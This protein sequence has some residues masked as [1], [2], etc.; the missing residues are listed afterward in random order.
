MSVGLNTKKYT[1]EELENWIEAGKLRAKIIPTKYVYVGDNDFYI[2]AARVPKTIQGKACLG[3]YWTITIK[4]HFPDGAPMLRK[5]YMF[6]GQLSWDEARQYDPFYTCIYLGDEI[7]SMDDVNAQKDYLRRVLTTS[8]Y[9]KL[10]STLKDPFAVLKAGDIETLCKVPGIQQKTAEK[11]IFRYQEKLEQASLLAFVERCGINLNSFQEIINYFGSAEAAI[12]KIRE[13]P[14]SLTEVP[15]YGFKKTDMFALK[16]GV[17]PTSVYRYKALITHLIDTA[18]GGVTYVK[19]SWLKEQ[20]AEY[21]GEYYILETFKNAAMQ[22][23]AENKL[24]FTPDNT[25]FA[26]MENMFLESRILKEMIRLRDAE[27]ILKPIPNEEM[28]T[29]IR[30]IEVAQGFT[31]TDEQ[32]DAIYKVMNNNVLIITGSGGTG[33]T[34]V[35]N[36]FLN[37]VDKDELQACLCALSGRAACRISEVSGLEASTIHK[38]LSTNRLSSAN[39]VVLDEATMVDTTLF[40][41]LVKDIP[42]GCKFIIMGDIAQLETIGKGNVFGDLL[43]ANSKDK[44]NVLP[45]VRLTKIHR[46]AATSG[47]ITESFNISRGTHITPALW[48]GKVK[49][50]EKQDL[51]LDIFNYDETDREISARKVIDYWEKAYAELKDIKKIAVVTARRA[52]AVLSTQSL[53]EHIQ[54]LYNPAAE[55]KHEVVFYKTISSKKNDN[56]LQ[57][58]GEQ[59][60]K[61]YAMVLRQGD[62]VMNLR[63]NYTALQVLPDIDPLMLLSAETDQ[64]LERLSM[65]ITLP[66]I[67]IY[68]GY[69]GTV[70]DVSPNGMIV[71]FDLIGRVF[72]TPTDFQDIDLGYASTVHKYQGSECHTV[73]FAIDK[74]AGVGFDNSMVTRQLLYTGMTRAREDC[75]MVADDYT[76]SFGTQH[77]KVGEKQTLLKH[78]IS[79]A[80]PMPSLEQ[81]VEYADLLEKRRKYKEAERQAQLQWEKEKI[82]IAIAAQINKEEW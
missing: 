55:G 60:Y 35:T 75:I 8:Q 23:R 45:T 17:N 11:L 30:D 78:F 37:I 41:N 27:S 71:D 77:D 65:T 47:I 18:I 20:M 59:E 15:G 13:N 36:G 58:N 34:S 73:I 79:G 16:M 80:L 6:V 5:E 24:F 9:D 51:L 31:F 49:K 43:L 68:N 14:Y 67:A 63:N 12:A 54:E 53:N 56:K 44:K 7:I 57:S 74:S 39:V 22:L 19:G 26:L 70:L 81:D 4:G 32:R 61:K 1:T 50:G 76:L 38:L 69:L 10:F 66:K 46:Q 2:I 28:E 62:R 29:K 40:Y 42:D 72:L 52:N 64:Y 21:L 33:K 25:L 48:N 3:L 82:K